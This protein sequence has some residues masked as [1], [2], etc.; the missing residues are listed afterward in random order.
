M[1]E[2]NVYIIECIGAVDENAYI[3]AFQCAATIY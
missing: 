3:I 1:V 2:T